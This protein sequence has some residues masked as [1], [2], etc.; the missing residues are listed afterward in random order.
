MLLTTQ[1]NMAYIFIKHTDLLQWFDSKYSNELLLEYTSK[2][3][4]FN[5]LRQSYASPR[6]VQLVLLIRYDSDGNLFCKI[7]CP[8]NPLPIRGE[9]NAVSLKEIS[10]YLAENGWTERQRISLNLCK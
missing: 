3:V 1:Y 6:D 4:G 7:K 2:S 10:K 9:F 5:Q 8:I